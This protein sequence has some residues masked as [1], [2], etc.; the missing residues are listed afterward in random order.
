MQINE[1]EFLAK[2][3]PKLSTDKTLVVP[4]GDDCAAIQIGDNELLLVTVDQ[5]AD[6]I[7]YLSTNHRQPTPAEKVGRKLLARNI[8]DIAA[9]GG[10]PKYCVMAIA[11]SPEYDESWLN[12]FSQGVIDLA[13]KFHILVIGGDLSSAKANVSS[14]TLL[15]S[16]DPKTICRRNQ[17]SP[18]DTIFVTGEFGGSLVNGKHLDFMP[19]LEEA[20]WLAKNGYTR[21]MIDVS[22]G[23]LT[24]LSRMCSAAQVLAVVNEE[25]VPRTKIEN[26]PVSLTR[27]FTDG[28]D[29]ELIFSVSPRHQREVLKNWPFSTRLTEIGKFG[30][31][32]NETLIVNDKNHDLIEHYGK[33][34]DHFNPKD[35]VIF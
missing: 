17:A 20:K 6:D 1:E 33:G 27:S 29:Y 7:H 10:S 4:P 14:I 8:S 24:D 15:G 34:F 26:K 21:A 31:L 16:V 19:R 5:V 9:M 12:E 18:G 23:L 32:L 22:D 11:L 25:A 35:P 2:L 13:K 3:F 28:E 30:Q